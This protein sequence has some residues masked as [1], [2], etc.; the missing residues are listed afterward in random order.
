MSDVI[1][2]FF[3]PFKVSLMKI[4]ESSYIRGKW[5]KVE[6]LVFSRLFLYFLSVVN[7]SS[8]KLSLLA[9]DT[10]TN[11]LLHTLKTQ[12]NFVANM[13]SG[14]RERKRER[15]REKERERERC[16]W[17]IGIRMIVLAIPKWTS[18]ILTLLL[19]LCFY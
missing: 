18:Y 1:F 19:S 13:S 12:I 7:H 10:A 15:E 4:M 8:L 16:C 14:E 6:H 17:Y 5:S 11:Q 2:I 3:F 9:R